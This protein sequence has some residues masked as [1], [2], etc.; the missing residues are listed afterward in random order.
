MS[1]WVC[2]DHSKLHRRITVCILMTYFFYSQLMYK[3]WDCYS[4]KILFQFFFSLAVCHSLHKCMQGKHAARISY[5]PKLWR[6][7]Q[8]GVAPSEKILMW[9]GHSFLILAHKPWTP[10][11]VLLCSLYY[12]FQKAWF[13]LSFFLS[14]YFLHL[15]CDIFLWCLNFVS[16][17]LS[18]EFIFSVP[19]EIFFPQ[20]A[21]ILISL[22]PFHCGEWEK[23]KFR[24]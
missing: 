4:K 12:F 14:L 11:W 17:F 15:N 19:F 3:F 16:L 23:W 21:L 7:N 8:G 10:F 9:Q 24:T 1:A 5:T 18:F 20:T 2:Q 22:D 13:Y 6:R